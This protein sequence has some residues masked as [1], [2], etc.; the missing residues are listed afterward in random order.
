MASSSIDPVSMNSLP[1]HFRYLFIFYTGKNVIHVA[2]HDI[3]CLPSE[4][5]CHSNCLLFIDK[6]S[7]HCLP[8]DE[9]R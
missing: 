1:K 2:Y 5:I 4:T 3:R 6:D 7:V 8:C 9:Y